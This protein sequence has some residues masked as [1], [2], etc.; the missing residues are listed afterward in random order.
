[1]TSSRR[2]SLTRRD[3]LAATAAG[4]TVA[5]VAPAIRASD[6]TGNKTKAI[7]GVEPYQYEVIHDCVE[8]PSSFTWQTTHNVAVDRDNNLYVIHEG[9]EELRDHPSIF[10][11]D[12]QGRLIRSFGQQFQGG[13]HGLEVRTEGSEQFLYVCAYQQ[14]KSFAKLSLDGEVVWQRWAPMQSGIY[15]DEEDTNPQKKWG[16]DRF[17]PTNFA[18]LD[19]GDFF[20]SDGYGSYFIHRY[21]KDGNW[22]S[23]FGGPGE[24]QGKFNT[25]HGLWVDQRGGAEPTLVVTDR[26]HHQIQVLSLNGEHQ[27]TLEGFGLPANVD[28]FQDLLLVPELLARVTL[29]DKDL[30]VVAQLGDDR[31]RIQNDAG[32][33]IRRDASQWQAGRFVHPHDA[34]FDREGNIYV[35]EWVATGRVSKLLRIT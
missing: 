23:C 6:K 12:P 11:F 35:A 5:W 13:G 7:V 32:Y 26:A 14:V 29:L 24:G 28:T 31:E 25:P 17:L 9:R 30:H 3:F 15:A 4:T 27:R 22:K 18:F 16:L 10:V 2:S 33:Q 8:L 21:D 1:M 34:C 19:D 20:L